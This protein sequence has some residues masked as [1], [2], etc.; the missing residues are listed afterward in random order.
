MPLG[1]ER[2]DMPLGMAT[3]SQYVHANITGG[4]H[5]ET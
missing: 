4:I 2:L 5:Y 3:R 1:I